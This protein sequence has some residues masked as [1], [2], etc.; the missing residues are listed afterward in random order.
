M[1]IRIGN[2]VIKLNLSQIIAIVFALII[3]AGSLLLALPFSSVTGK[4]CGYFTALFTAVSCVCVTGLSVVDIWSTYSMFGQVVLLILMEVGGLGFMSIVSL[5][6]YFTNHK[7]NVQSLSLIAESI[8]ADGISQIGRIQKR[9]LIGSFGFEGIAADILFVHFI[10]KMG[11]GK[12]L[13]Y[14]IFHAVSSFCNAGFDLFGY[15]EPGSSLTTLAD[16]PVV[17]ITLGLLVVIGG[18]GFVVWDDIISKPPRRWSVY[19]KLVLA[20][21]TFLLVLGTVMYF[22]LEYANSDTIGNMTM[23]NK[24]VNAFF[25]SV[26]TR[27]AGFAAVNQGSLTTPSIALTIMLMLIGGSAGSTAGGVKTVTVF[28][29]VK[30]L[31]SGASGRKTVTVMDRTITNEQINYA[32]AIVGNSIL[33]SLI[34][35]FVISLTSGFD[36]YS[37]YFE[38]VSALATVGISVGITSSV[39]FVSKILIMIFMYIGRVGLLTLTIGFFKSK[40]NPAIKYP[41]VKIM[42]G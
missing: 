8:G 14:G 6:F 32:Y 11:A 30:V 21:T 33:L 7:T 12:A 18:I 5:M 19:T 25:Q 42:I 39:S 17:L 31:L 38:S 41:P 22:F 37:S 40:E 4:S 3:L 28:I 23:G 2:H 27:T 16:D 13:S 1:S 35:G 36:F 20:M 15:V 26:T 29:V 24:L 34:G 9:L 10:P